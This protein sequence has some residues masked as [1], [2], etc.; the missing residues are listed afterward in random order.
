MCMPLVSKWLSQ[1]PVLAQQIYAKQFSLSNDAVLAKKKVRWRTETKVT[2]KQRYKG[3][4]NNKW[5]AFK[6]FDLVY[7]KYIVRTHE[8]CS[9]N[10]Q[11]Q[12]NSALFFGTFDSSL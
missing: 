5:C 3:G 10:E 12:N 8:S 11:K 7:H 9:S 6:E 1:T 4:N 2:A